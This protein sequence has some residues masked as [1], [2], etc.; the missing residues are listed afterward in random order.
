M[1]CIARL[2][3]VF[4]W[5]AIMLD[6]VGEYEGTKERI[7]KAFKIKEHF[8]VR[9]T[10]LLFFCYALHATSNKVHFSCRL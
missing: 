7:S 8:V 4:Q 2:M 3:F 6:Y 10:L 1:Q 9:K 5:Y